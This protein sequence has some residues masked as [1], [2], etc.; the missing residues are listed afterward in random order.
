VTLP[1]CY[2]CGKQP[3]VCKD[4]ITLY[5]ADCRDVLPLLEP[6][7]VD[8]V[9]TDPVY[10]RLDDYAM[11]GR[12]QTRCLSACFTNP[13]WLRETLPLIPTTLPVLTYYNPQGAGMCGKVITKAHHVLLWG[14]G[15]LLSCIP[16]CWYSTPWCRPH[17]NGHKWTKN[18]NYYRLLLGALSPVR[19]TVLDPFAGSGTTG[20]ACKDL[21]R[22]CIM[23]EIEERY[24]EIAAN[25][26]R[27]EVL[28]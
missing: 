9:L 6:G 5:H 3:C 11:L 8:L 28:F 19:A 14:E 20:R 1:P 15:K 26:L 10:G 13:K 18:P 23:V 27:Q 21:G 24:C 4:G 12:M 25:R 7:S 16:D 22:R 2:R 17:E